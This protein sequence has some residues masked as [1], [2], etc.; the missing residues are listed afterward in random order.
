MICKWCGAS[1]GE[2]AKVCP[3]CKEKV[4]PLSDCGG[5]YGLV[6]KATMLMSGAAASVPEHREAGKSPTGLSTPPTPRTPVDYLKDLRVIL[7]I[8][9]VL[10]LLLL[11]ITSGKLRKTRLELKDLRSEYND[12]CREIDEYEDGEAD[13]GRGEDHGRHPEDDKPGKDPQQ[14]EGEQTEAT[15]VPT[16][17]ATE[18]TEASETDPT[19]EQP[20]EEQPTE[21]QPTEEQPTETDGNEE[22]P[23]EDRPEDPTQ[24]VAPT[25]EPELSKQDVSIVV[26]VRKILGKCMADLTVTADGQDI[27]AKIA[28]KEF[29]GKEQSLKSLVIE[30]PEYPECVKVRTENKISASHEN[31]GILSAKVTVDAAAFGK[32]KGDVNYTWQWRIGEGQWEDIDPEIFTKENES[33]AYAPTALL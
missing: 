14:S 4:Q 19:E 32:A 3:R 22:N 17:Q 26:T 13:E 30:L 28:A 10:A 24:T 5:F 8:V 23:N 2:S 11:L 21:E 20:T 33:L 12:L 18:S 9:A 6:P 15:T 31:K 7:G 27:G 1:L 16:T 25:D 29:D